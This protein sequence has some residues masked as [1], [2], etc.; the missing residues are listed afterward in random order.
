MTIDLIALAG[1]ISVILVLLGGFMKLY[2]PIKKQLNRMDRLER[3]TAKQQ[4]DIESS[5]EGRL[6]I[7]SGVLAC[8]EGLKEHGC[9]GCVNEAIHDI[10]KYMIVQAHRGVS[11]NPDEPSADD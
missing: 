2:T 5:K 10:K 11:Y 6:V 8:L 9:N 4:Q 7:I 1:S 3:W